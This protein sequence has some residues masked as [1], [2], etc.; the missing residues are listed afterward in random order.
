M[1]FQHLRDVISF[2]TSVLF[3]SSVQHSALTA[4]LLDIYGFVPN[5]P[6]MLLRPPLGKKARLAESDVR[7]ALAS[8]AI[9]SDVIAACHSITA[10]WETQ[11]GHKKS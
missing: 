5:V 10:Y 8:R 2:V 4:C 9:T 11:V 3:T 1:E 6:T 7:K